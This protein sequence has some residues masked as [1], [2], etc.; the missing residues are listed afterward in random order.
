MKKIVLMILPLLLLAFALVSCSSAG[1][2]AA[3]ADTGVTDAETEAPQTT[4]A[5]EAAPAGYDESARLHTSGSKLLTND[6][7]QVLLRGFGSAGGEFMAKKWD[8]WYN[9]KSFTAIKNMGCNVF[10]LMVEINDSCKQGDPYA[11][12]YCKYVERCISH[13]IYIVVAWMGNADFENYTDGA[14]AFFGYVTDK[15][16]DNPYILYEILNEP[17]DR[18]WKDIKAYSETIIPAIREKAPSALIVVPTGFGYR[19]ETTNSAAISD[20]LAFD[21]ILYQEHMYVGSSLKAPKLTETTALI[22]AGYPVIF[23]EWGTTNGNGRDNFYFDYSRL[24]LQYCEEHDV[25]W[26]NFQLSDFTPRTAV[27]YQSSVCLPGK[28]TD[29]LADASL[30]DSGR[31]MKDYF[32]HGLPA[33]TASVMMNYAEGSA[34]WADSVR[35]TI[36]GV[37][38]VRDNAFSG[39]YDKSWDV[40]MLPGSGDVM[41]YL[42]G[43][44]L[45]I[46]ARIGQVMSPSANDNLFKNFTALT[47]L[48]LENYDTT[49]CNY[50]YGLFVGCSSLETID[51]SNYRTG[52]L[53]TFAAEFKNCYRLK[54]IDLRGCDLSKIDSL[55]SS[56]YNCYALEKLY[57]PDLI[58][59]NIKNTENAFRNMGSST[60]PT[61]VVFADESDAVLLK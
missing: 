7:R 56:F 9:D 14:L 2:P 17:F 53:T 38:F 8:T 10:R 35:T 33:P 47:A 46:V 34:F 11:Q 48:S 41:A 22:D 23:T 57:L 40:S 60:S 26:C 59:E 36:T 20:P 12:E 27:I 31:M 49:W 1:T 24:F 54:E 15:F 42:D 29:D 19:G 6:G 51:L 25:N 58:P 18:T 37:H 45:Y 13:G 21:N 16:G 30:S 44:V 50:T 3:A 52:N 61:E 43:T 28:W 5:P 55:Q 32:E 4:D 39:A